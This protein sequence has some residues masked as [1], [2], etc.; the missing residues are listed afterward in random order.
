M[1]SCDRE[2]TRD[3]FNNPIITRRARLAKGMFDG[4][5]LIGVL[6]VEEAACRGASV[7]AG[8]GIGLYESIQDVARTIKFRET[9]V[10]PPPG[11]SEAYRERYHLVYRHIYPKVRDL[12]QEIIKAEKTS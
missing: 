12:H 9:L 7:L 4:P 5:C 6:E 11:W 1:S 10:D 2:R 3:I 8:L